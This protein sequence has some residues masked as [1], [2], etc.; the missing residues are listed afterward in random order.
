VPFDV[1]FSVLSHVFRDRCL[2][3]GQAWFSALQI[4]NKV[5]CFKGN[6][7]YSVRGIFWLCYLPCINF[8]VLQ[9]CTKIT[10]WHIQIYIVDIFCT[11]MHIGSGS[12]VKNFCL[13]ACA[14][15][16][17]SVLLSQLFKNHE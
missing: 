5:A 14:W 16:F 4:G 12:G 6:N 11:L 3:V 15:E 9:Y 10:I 13:I 1:H 7:S 17:S 8:G 2:G